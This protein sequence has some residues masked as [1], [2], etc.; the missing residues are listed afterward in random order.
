MINLWLPNGAG[1]GDAKSGLPE[2]RRLET[3][4]LRKA[5]ENME[6]QKSDRL[7]VEHKEDGDV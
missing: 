3:D 2:W 5:R 1:V 7:Y 4:R 6:R